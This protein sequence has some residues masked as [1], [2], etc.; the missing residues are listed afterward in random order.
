MGQVA[1]SPARNRHHS[2][3]LVCPPRVAIMLG[4]IMVSGDWT[5]PP[6][7]AESLSWPS[8]PGAQI[9]PP[10]PPR[11]FRV[12]EGHPGQ[13]HCELRRD[14]VRKGAPQPPAQE[15]SAGDNAS[16][17]GSEGRWGRVGEVGI[18]N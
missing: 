10:P 13:V 1:L 3:L 14:K 5:F 11:V 7:T 15:G 12:W 4:S 8:C 6:R 18:G 16:S 2:K 9:T 17:S